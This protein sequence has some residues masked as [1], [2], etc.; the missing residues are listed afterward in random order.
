MKAPVIA[1]TLMALALPVTLMAQADDQETTAT[2]EEA[3]EREALREALEQARREVAEAA[4]TM[5]RI[6]REL[7]D[8][9][10]EALHFERLEALEDMERLQA[11]EGE[12]AHMEER[13]HRE[14]IRG[15]RMTRPRLGVLLGGEDDPNE[16]VGV[17]PGSGAEKAGIESGD[18]LV[19]INGRAVDAADPESLRAP[20][21]GVEP[22]DTVPVEIERDAERM[23]FDVTVSSPARDFRVLTH[24]I[25]GPPP[26]PDA[27]EAP[28]IDR[29][30]IVLD[31]SGTWVPRAPMPP[32]PP[33]LAGLGRHSDMIS[34]HAGLEPYFGTADGVVVLR[35]DADNPLQLRDGDVVLSIDGETVS[36]PVEI[37]RALL[38]QVGSSVTLEIMRAGERITLEAELP[39][40]EAVSFLF[41]RTPRGF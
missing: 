11:L 37:G 33:R 32:L 25:K 21:E 40:S 18:R 19:A 16:I 36:R 13:I 31:G 9:D 12:M 34:N 35:I 39:A 38:G 27:P 20:M 23:T 41:E 1:L 29:E 14:V 30:V 7:A 17:T 24:D 4:R 3:A 28:R 22:G 2:A 15:L 6:Q 5:A 8:V 26:A 10:R